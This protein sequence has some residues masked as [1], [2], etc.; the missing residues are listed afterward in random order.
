[1]QQ[2]QFT[3]TEETTLLPFLREH[4]TGM[5]RNA[6][7]SLLANKQVAIDG[8]MSTKFDA[9]LKVGQLVSIAP[10]GEA[11]VRLDFK[12]LFEDDALI[13]VDKPAGLLTIASDKEKEKTAY[14]QV[15]AYVQAKNPKHRIFVVHRLD[16]DTSGVLV[17][18]KNEKL[19]KDLQDNWEFF[20]K[21]RV[22][23]AVVEGRL[24]QST[25][26]IESYLHETATHLVYSASPKGGKKAVTKYDVLRT[27][28]KY[29]LVRLYLQTGRKNQIRVH[30]KEAGCPVA[31]DKKYDAKTNPIHRLA[32]HASSLSLTR[33]D[34][35]ETLTWTSRLPRLLANLVPQNQEK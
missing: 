21:H 1:M 34:T 27:E 13:V 20:V 19:K 10:P 25:G 35:N 23:E 6:V 26:T 9:V 14:H 29:S 15:R 24:P 22:Y 8:K 7:K 28:G 33:P 5:A 3:V 2:K 18:A 4:M 30:M 31:G 12:I 11:F 17:F 32:L 16:R